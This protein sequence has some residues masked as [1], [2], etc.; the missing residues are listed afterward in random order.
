MYVERK[1]SLYIEELR[2]EFKDNLHHFKDG[3]RAFDRLIGHRR[4]GPLILLS[5]KRN[6]YKIRYSR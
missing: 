3:D 5:L 6:Q 1:P 2:S 4:T